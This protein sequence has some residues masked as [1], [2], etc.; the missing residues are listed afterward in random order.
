[1]VASGATAARDVAVISGGLA[2]ALAVCLVVGGGRATKNWQNQAARRLLTL[3][4]YLLA[5]GVICYPWSIATTIDRTVHIVDLAHLTSMVMVSVT[6]ILMSRFATEMHDEANRTARAKVEHVGAGLLVCYVLVW[7]VAHVTIRETDALFANSYYARPLILGVL[8]MLAGVTFLVAGSA[9]SY[10]LWT[11]PRST[12]T[13]RITISG[14][15]L[16]TS[17]TIVYGLAICVQ[18]LIN[19]RGGDPQALHH[20]MVPLGLAGVAVAVL[21]GLVLADGLRLAPWVTG[22]LTRLLPANRAV[23]PT[24]DPVADQ[25]HML[26]FIDEHMLAARGAV[27]GLLEL[28]EYLCQERG[29]SEEHTKMALQATRVTILDPV[30]GARE[31]DRRVQMFCHY[32]DRNN[33]FFGDVYRIAL[34]TLGTVALPIGSPL[35]LIE[36]WHEELAGI[37]REAVYQYYGPERGREILLKK[38]LVTVARRPVAR[39]KMDTCTPVSSS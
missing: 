32:A 6:L 33:R 36:P 21:G 38:G 35:P 24:H 19:A 22:L 27:M 12:R 3:T 29:K 25:I 5:L 11:V 1:M 9:A 23:D 18:V 26:V 15:G 4:Y 30:E 2:V 10:G 37:I 7:I 17:A 31:Y 8:N 28:V 14:L 34:T 16:G 13:E 20:Y 39:R